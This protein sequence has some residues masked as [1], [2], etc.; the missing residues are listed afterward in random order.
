MGCIKKPL[1]S[2]GGEFHVADAYIWAQIYY[3][4]SS[5]DY[6]EC[7]PTSGRPQCSALQEPMILLDDLTSHSFWT[8]FVSFIFAEAVRWFTHP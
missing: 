6:R 7:L 2:G 8:A 4:D 3:L 1:P 5:T